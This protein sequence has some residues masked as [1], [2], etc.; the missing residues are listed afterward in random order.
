MPD[1]EELPVP[2]GADDWWP[3]RVIAEKLGVSSRQMN[4]WEER[5]ENNGF[6]EP[7]KVQGRFKFYDLPEVQEWVFFHH[8]ATMN[9]H[10]NLERFNGKVES[11]EE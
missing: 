7:K 1:M 2:H 10:G 4:R 8:R 9:M 11:Q 5:R 3:L 6:P